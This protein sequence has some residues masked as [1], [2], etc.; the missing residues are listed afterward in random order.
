MKRT[1]SELEQLIYLWREEF[2]KE[3][4][5]YYTEKD[6]KMAERKYIKYKIKECYKIENV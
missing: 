4:K 2:Y 5:D 3:N 6:Y 1:L